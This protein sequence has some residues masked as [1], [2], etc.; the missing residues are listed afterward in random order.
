MDIDSVSDKW[1]KLSD[2]YCSKE[3]LDRS[4]FDRSIYNDK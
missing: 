4:I 1:L 3:L 2:L